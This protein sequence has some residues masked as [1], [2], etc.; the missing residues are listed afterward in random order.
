MENEP[1]SKGETRSSK[2]ETRSSKGES[3]SSKGESRSS[4]GESRETN[5]ESVQNAKFLCRIFDDDHTQMIFECRM[6]SIVSLFSLRTS[7][8]SLR[9]SRFSLRTSRFSL[10]IS[11]FSLRDSRFSLRD[12]LI[13]HTLY[14]NE[15]RECDDT[16]SLEGR[17]EK[18]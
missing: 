11:R 9:T 7:R 8:F 5:G 1:I 6:I 16:C 14:A 17:N 10:R 3:R 2:G 12:W 13:L 4:K 18:K 15:K